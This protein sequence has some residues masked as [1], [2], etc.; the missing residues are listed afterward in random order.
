[1]SPLVEAAAVGLGLGVVTGMP[2]GVVNVAI[3]DAAAT[4]RRRFASG[5]GFGG[6]AAD[7]IHAALAFVGVGTLV[8]SRPEL[9]R[10]LAIAAALL[11]VAYAVVAW[12][13][14]RGTSPIATDDSR[15]LHGLTTGFALTLP[16]PGALAAWVAV[17]AS[18]KPDA[19]IVEACVVAAGVGIGSAAWFALLARVISGVRSDHWAIAAV[20]RVALVALVAIAVIGVVRAF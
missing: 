14:R 5:V 8:T 13:K 7:T 9:V 3:V 17:A 12:R 20:P 18:L 6:A 15:M 2:L 16:N 10:A 19:T 4:G 11:I 1:V